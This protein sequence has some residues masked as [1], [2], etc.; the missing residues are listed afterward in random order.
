MDARVQALDVLRQQP[1]SSAAE[2]VFDFW[3]RPSAVVAEQV[4]DILKQEDRRSAATELL[5]NPQ[6]LVIERSSFIF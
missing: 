4:A 6:Y 1:I 3:I 2:V 5:N